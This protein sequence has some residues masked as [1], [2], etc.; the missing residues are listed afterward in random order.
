MKSFFQAFLKDMASYLS[1]NVIVIVLFAFYY[2][3]VPDYWLLCSVLTLVI[4]A[5]V[6]I[7]IIANK[8]R[9]T[10]LDFH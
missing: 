5:V 6:E 4:A 7:F 1:I 2:F 8:K 10:H 9:K 3:V